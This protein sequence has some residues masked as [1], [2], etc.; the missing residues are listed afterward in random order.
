MFHTPQCSFATP[1]SC[2]TIQL[3]SDT[4]YSEKG[5]IS[6]ANSSV[7]QDCPLL[8]LQTQTQV[9]TVTCFW[10]DRRFQPSS[11]WVDWFARAAHRTQRNIL[12]TIFVYY[13]RVWGGTS[14]RKRWPGQDVWERVR[15]LHTLGRCALSLH[16]PVLT[17]PEGNS[18][19]ILHPSSP[20]KIRAYW[21]QKTWQEFS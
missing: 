5:Q 11:P 7:L 6:E 20:P 1:P 4:V 3:N 8:L 12:L 19:W 16:L 18:L 2:L 9:H 10:P 15:S 14:R 21:N 13:K 17:S